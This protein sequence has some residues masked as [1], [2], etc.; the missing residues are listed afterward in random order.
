MTRRLL[1]FAAVLAASGCGR[2]AA[3]P[4]PPS[5]RALQTAVVE[6]REVRRSIDV[7]GT[8][9]GRVEAVV[10]SRLAAPVSEVS[11]VPGRLVHAGQVLVRLETR[12]S[13]GAL[14]GARA[15]AAAAEAAWQIARRNRERF[16]RLSERGAAAGVELDR[17]TQEESAARAQVAAA[18][19]NLR[20]AE[21]DRG[22]SMLTAPFDAIVVEKMVSP[23]DLAV[24][25][26]PLVRLASASGRRVEASPGEEEAA[27]VSVGDPVEVVVAG[28]TLPGRV[29]EIVGSVDRETRRR[30]IRVDLPAD[31]DPAIGSFARVRLPGTVE[32]RLVA[33]RSALR[34]Q[35]GL[36]IAWAVGR[37]G[38]AEL[39]YVRTGESSGPDA[40]EIR[41]GLSAGERV[42]VDPPADLSAGT[43]LSP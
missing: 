17:A 7:D 10:S 31:A 33:P 20:R 42:V 26:R 18:Q 40:V 6:E 30:S 22:Q 12:E 5:S 43:R 41:A 15:G 39:R 35:G 19:A 24:P 1:V 9:I 8:V 25:G 36:R 28:R 2:S 14:E 3:P 38:R 23:G 21:T 34:D 27:R 11:A 37:D 13:E 32:R 4:P 29:A 16:T